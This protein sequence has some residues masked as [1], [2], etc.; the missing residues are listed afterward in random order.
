MDRPITA[1]KSG[2]SLVETVGVVTVLGILT[3]LALAAIGRIRPA[4]DQ[5]KLEDQVSQLNAAVNV[6]KGSGGDLNTVNDPALVIAKLKTRMHKD[7]ARTFVGFTGTTIDQR[8][9]LVSVAA[10]F[11]G[12]RAVYDSASQKFKVTTEAVDGYRFTFD[13]SVPV[14]LPPPETRTEGAVA[15]AKESTWVWDYT[16]SPK[17]YPDLAVVDPVGTYTDSII[18]PVFVEVDP[19]S[20]PSAGDLRKLLPPVF[21]LPPGS[22]DLSDYPMALELINPNEIGKILY[23]N[24]NS[25]GWEWQEYIEP[26]VVEPSSKIVAFVESSRPQLYHNSNLVNSH[27]EWSEWLSR[28]WFEVSPSSISKVD[29]VSSISILHNNDPTTYTDQGIVFSSPD[30]FEVRYRI[31]PLITGQGT[32]TSW[33]TYSNP[34][35]VTAS[36]YPEGFTVYA[37]VVSSEPNFRESGTRTTTVHTYDP[38]DFTDPNHPDNPGDPDP[39]AEK[40]EPSEQTQSLAPPLF[41]HTTDYYDSGEFPLT[42][43]LTDPNPPGAGILYYNVAGVVSEYIGP[44]SVDPNTQ[45]TAWIES[46]DE[47]Q[48]QSSSQITHSYMLAVEPDSP[49]ISLS[50]TEIDARW[51]SA[52]I[53]LSYPQTSNTSYDIQYQLT[54]KVAGE[55]YATG[56]INYTGEFGVGGP[57][58][59]RGFDITARLISSDPSDTTVREATAGVDAYYTLDPPDIFSSN[60]ALDEKNSTAI[61]E[62]QDPN[63]YGSAQLE[64]QVLGTN[65]APSSVWQIYSSPFTVD[66]S[67]FPDGVRVVARSAPLDP[68]YRTSGQTAKPLAVSFFD[69]TVTW[70]TIFVLDSSGSM[71]TNDRLNRL[72]DQ[73]VEVLEQFGD[74]DSFAIIDYDDSATVLMGWGPGTD[75][76]KDAAFA[77]L[78]SMSADGA[79]NYH[80]SLQAALDLSAADATQV[81]F[82]SDGLP[83]NPDLPDPEVTD[84]ILEL[85]DQ[86]V[87]TNVERVDTIALGINSQILQDMA[88]RGNGSM[89]IV[90]D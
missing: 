78:D 34:I 85:V 90:N 3:L 25:A 7:Q 60:D 2:F 61:I 22:Y 86:I 29:G 48:Y 66:G 18:P 39:P 11:T 24:L 88:D 69:I 10:D 53:S 13:D 28:P 63:P 74:D 57:Q 41:S 51:G 84:G 89:V 36:Q 32:E 64:Y 52:T 9:A 62:L 68:Y 83:F 80:A 26:V 82:L 15:F 5:I 16:D 37:K 14:S 76:R 35:Q 81:I 6:Y 50:E 23:A 59:P 56:W 77:S 54:P 12:A 45:I 49:T 43:S 79:T 42:V 33:F 21:S 38:N 1:H 47:V 72:K 31:V 67:L 30:P 71:V 46:L 17:T 73:V 20:P 19:A 70:Q 58:F 8:L 4:T 27:Y 40:G 65:E 87:A 55:G 44:I 75:T